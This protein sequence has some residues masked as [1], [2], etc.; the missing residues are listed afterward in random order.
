MGDLQ[1]VWENWYLWCVSP[2]KRPCDLR[3][4][5]EQPRALAEAAFEHLTVVPKSADTCFKSYHHQSGILH[6]PLQD[7]TYTGC[8][9]F[10]IPCAHAQLLQSRLTLC[11]PMTAACQAPLSMGILQA[12]TLEWIAMPSSRGPSWPRDWTHVSCTAGGFFTHWATWEAWIYV[13][14]ELTDF[15]VQQKL[16]QHCKA[17]IVQ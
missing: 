16:T 13:Y 8:L 1:G 2:S 14:I 4:R 7:K 11:N 3:I 9:A 12:R 15:A 6:F 5:R 17:T 10:F